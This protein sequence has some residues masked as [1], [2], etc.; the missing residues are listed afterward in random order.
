[1]ETDKLNNTYLYSAI[2]S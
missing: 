2:W 1:M